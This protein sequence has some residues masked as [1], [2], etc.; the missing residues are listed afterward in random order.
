[1]LKEIKFR[2]RKLSVPII[3]GGMG[4]GISLSNLA[5][6]VMRESGMGVISAAHPGCYKEGFKTNT[7]QCNMDAFAEEIRKARYISE[8]RGLLGVNIMCASEDY[9]D[10]VKV[11]CRENVDAIISGAGL[12]L[13][14]PSVA[15]NKDVLLAPIVSSVKAFNVIAK[16][17]DKH[18]GICPDFIVIEGSMAGGHLGFKK[19]QILNG[20]CESAESILYGIRDAKIPYENKYGFKIPIFVAGGIF[21]GKDI[22]KYLKLGADG[23]QMGTRFIATHECDASNEF[24]NAIINCKKDDIVII[25]SPTGFPGRALKN[26]FTESINPDLKAEITHCYNCMIP[27][28]PSNT[29]YCISDALINAAKGDTENGVVF[30]GENAYRIKKAV[31]VKELTDELIREANESLGR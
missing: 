23:V 10:Y 2:N 9:D 31:S 13:K 16:Y 4:I 15:D 19:E 30:A 7:F 20:N 27:C 5:G 6:S 29:I 1:M 26:R 11:A 28:N 17:W 14:L 24:K 18:Y 25:D 8:G 3:Q 22:A 21:D 12:P